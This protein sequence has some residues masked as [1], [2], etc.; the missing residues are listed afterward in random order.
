MSYFVFLTI[1]LLA[2]LVL[3]VGLWRRTR[4]IAF[5]FGFA[6]LYF[7]TFHGAWAI[8][9]DLAGGD[10]QKNYVYLFDKMFAIHLDNDYAWT[11]ALYAV[12]TWVTALTVLGW[13]RPPTAH[14]SP[15]APLEISHDRLLIFC[16]FAGLASYWIVHDTLD[17]AISTGVSGY[18]ETRMSTDIGW[19]RLHQLLNRVALVPPA[20]GFATLVSSGGY[21]LLRGAVHL[22][23]FLG[24]ATVLSLMFCFC[25]VLG[26]KNELA[27]ALFSGCLF[28]IANSLRPRVRRLS[29]CGVVL[30]ACVGFID[31]ARRFSIDEIVD[32]TSVS[33]IAY[34]LVRISN[35]SECFAAHMSLYGIL[36]YDIPLTY[37]SSIYSLLASVVPQSLWPDRPPDIYSY[38]VDGV[39]AIEGQGYT[40]HHAAAWYLNFGIAGIVLGGFLLGRIWAALYNLAMHARSR[41]ATVAWQAFCAVGFFTFTASLPIVIRCGPEIYKSVLIETFLIPVATLSIARVPSASSRRAAVLRTA[42]A[43]TKNARG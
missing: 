8:V 16:G 28:Y 32:Q 42:L 13:V 37:G 11:L 21:R 38:Y 17:A 6:V 31:H 36:S 18:L 10:S 24:Y 43:P 40:V 41:Q 30:L 3:C 27:F 26:N 34:S 4:S 33:E 25:V 15:F 14:T 35:S 39:G 19:F 29:I 23:H 5:P 1:N 7:W 12:F 20:I 9:T 22:R 2:M